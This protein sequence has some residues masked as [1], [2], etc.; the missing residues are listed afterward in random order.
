M[1]K[2]LKSVS[3][4]A[5]DIYI[6]RD[7]YKYHTTGYEIKEYNEKNIVQNDCTIGS[8]ILAERN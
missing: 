2:H 5:S 7:R 4:V 8:E 1:L 3:T 6:E